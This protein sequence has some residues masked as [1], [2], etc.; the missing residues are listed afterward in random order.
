MQQTANRTAFIIDGFNLYH[1]VRKASAD[2]GGVST[3]WL[4]IRSLCDSYLHLVGNGAQ[5]QGVYYFSALAHHL[6]VVNPGVV[7]RHQDF[8]RCLRSSGVDVELARFKKKDI[9][10]RTASALGDDC[11][12]TLKRHEEKETDVAI[13]TKLFELFINNQCD[14]ALLVT[15]DTDLAPACRTAQ[16]LFPGKTIGFAFPYKRKNKELAKLASLSFNIDKRHYATHQFQ[17]PFVLTNGKKVSK[18]PKW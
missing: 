12:G 17:D 5:T 13:A 8:N 6:S 14:T 4:D 10:F 16:R 2:L 3:K 1:S 7:Q 18:P 9:H 11:S 15:G